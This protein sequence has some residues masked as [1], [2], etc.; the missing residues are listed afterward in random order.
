MRTMKAIRIHQY[1][2]PEV[3]RYEDAPRPEAAAG[4][5]LVRVHAAGVNAVDWKV[6]EGYLQQVFPHELPLIPGWE[7]SGTVEEVGA[8]VEEFATGDEVYGRPDVLRDGAY[9][10]YI[11][12]R[13]QEVTQK[14]R[15]LDHLHAAAVPVG[16]LTAWQALFVA[17]APFSSIGLSM[18]QTILIHGAAGG[19]GSFA[20]Q[21]ARWRGA[22]VI[23]TGS[24]RNEGFLRELGADEFVDYTRQRFEDVVHDV[25]AVLDTIG[26]ET[27]SRSWK[28]LK[29]GG[30][31]AS[32]V[33][34]PSEAEARTHLA[35][36]AFVS[37]QADM[38]LLD[39]ITHLIDGKLLK[40]VLADVLP[41]AQA[42]QAQELSQ[43]GHVRG[44]IVLDVA[45]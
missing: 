40:P 15:S 6:R 24:A 11:V 10:E 36:A 43:A 33:S 3:L 4:E 17:P 35:R 9:A 28:V 27:Q 21:L 19:V 5:L 7:L 34:P 37:A 41:L 13:T 23:A 18:G 26:G 22:K 2:G 12:V 39:E 44:K 29:P 31:L 8:D 45:G 42:R 1:G 14:P 30:V 16:A 20:V 38:A 25:D 32:I